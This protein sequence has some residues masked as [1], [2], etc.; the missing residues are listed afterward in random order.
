[1]QCYTS[2]NVR[3]HAIS[4][5]N[6]FIFFY[7]D[8][9]SLKQAAEGV[10]F[11]R[12]LTTDMN[13]LI[14]RK[15]FCRT[16]PLTYYSEGKLPDGYPVYLYKFQTKVFNSSLDE[17]RCYCPED[18]CLPSGL[19]DISPCYYSEY[20]FDY[21]HTCVHSR[22]RACAQFFPDNSRD[23]NFFLIHN[24][25]QRFITYVFLIHMFNA[26]KSIVVYEI[27]SKSLETLSI[28]FNIITRLII[29]ARILLRIRT[30]NTLYDL[31]E[32]YKAITCAMRFVEL[33]HCFPP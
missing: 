29:S 30:L 31:H 12:H 7:R 28:V 11:P 13:F 23:T 18:G 15:A 33:L 32:M 19:S 25:R 22:Q 9:C 17:N 5:W 24:I 3:M 10:L 26:Q 8:K 2:P 21:S 1:M 14:Y 4:F 6:A 16:L 20:N 27:H